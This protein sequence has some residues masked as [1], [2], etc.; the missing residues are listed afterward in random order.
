MMLE[1][2]DA[3]LVEWDF[4]HAS[5][6]DPGVINVRLTD[7]DHAEMEATECGKLAAAASGSRNAEKGPTHANTI[8]A[9]LFSF[10]MMVGLET[11]ALMIDLFPGTVDPS[12]VLAWGPYMYFVGGL[13][14]IIVAIFQVLRNNIYGATAFLG[15]GSFWFSAGLRALL[16][17]YFVQ[18]GTDAAEL[19]GQPDPLGSFFRNLYILLF[20][21][22]LWK[23]T[24]V[25]NK[26]STTLIG[27]LCLKILCAS[28]TGWS[29]AMKWLQFVFGWLTSGFAFFVFFVEFTNNVYH[30]GKY[31]FRICLSLRPIAYLLLPFAHFRSLAHL[32]ME[33]A[34]FSR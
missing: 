32:Q 33:R 2:C 22:A 8:P 6:R 9:G 26:L 7:L 28:L 15:F 4:S 11:A 31:C 18:D 14:Q 34:R 17:T 30:R 24:L 13:M 27:L 23:Q 19:L 20:S 16:E 1:A 25:M 29:D 3:C 21:C 5:F 12:Y 10:S